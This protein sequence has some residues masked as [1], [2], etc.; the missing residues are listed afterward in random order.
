MKITI[1]YYSGAGNTRYINKKIVECFNHK[2]HMVKGEKISVVSNTN[3]VNEDFNMLGI[4][5][6]IYFREAPEL[7][8]DLV[9]KMDGKNRPIFFFVTKGMYSGNAVRNM[10]RFSLA[11]NFTPVGA[12]EFFMPGTDFL[13]L[14]AKQDS[15]TERLLK[16]IHSNNIDER[17]DH[18]VDN[19]LGKSSAEIPDRKWYSGFDDFV[20]K[21]LETIYDNQH[22]DCI[23][24]FYSNP[25]TCNGC[26]KCVNSCPRK[27]II[28]NDHI[29]F[30]DDCDVCFKCIH[31]CPTESIQIGTITKGNAR[32][33]K[34]ELL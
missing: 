25:D 14:F 1:R 8:Y 24:Q 18:F 3:G 22:K 30:G 11:Q 7:V 31:N 2:G 32:Y 15:P 17:L 19:L 28:L 27:N 34:V 13:M 29:K 5:F 12:I 20:V 21:R 16:K 26:M 23:G 6:P 33:R 9:G 10:M 4:G